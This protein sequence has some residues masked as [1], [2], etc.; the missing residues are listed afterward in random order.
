VKKKN[1]PSTKHSS[2]PDLAAHDAPGEAGDTATEAPVSA[3]AKKNDDPATKRAVPEA[4]TWR[5]TT[6]PL[7]WYS[8]RT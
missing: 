7:S 3:N 2:Q 8:E 4:V 6:T 5:L 1:D